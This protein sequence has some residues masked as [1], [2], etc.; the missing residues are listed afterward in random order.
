[1][2]ALEHLVVF[3][4]DGQR[5]ALYLPVV[6]RVVRAVE[7]TPLPKAPE[8]VLGVI[9][10]QGRIVPV[11]NMRKR[12]RLPEGEL[13]LGDQIVIARTSRRA[14]ALV[15]DAVSGV[16]QVSE[17]DFVSPKQIVPGTEYIE[18]VV[19][20]EDGLVLIYDL[21][22]FLSLDEE[23]TLDTSLNANG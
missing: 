13:K 2:S 14:V 23:R 11:V 9:N 17:K 18:G 10:V 21:D 20:L 8:I 12:F 6:E 16:M 1:M 22:Q 4:L 15:V 5:Y 19:K 3:T 7:V